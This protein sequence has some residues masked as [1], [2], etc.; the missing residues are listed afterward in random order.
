MG[1]IGYPR[2]WGRCVVVFCGITLASCVKLEI[3]PEKLISD[4]VRASQSVVETVKR[5]RQGATERDFQHT[6][7]LRAGADEQDAGIECLAFAT[8]LADAASAKPAE[9]IS[10][11][12]E[13]VKEDEKSML[14]CSIKAWVF[15]G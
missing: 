13:I 1:R 2:V 15:Q 12:T 10:R 5:K 6:L 8:K 11:S 14:L 4:T 9:V 7:P 3:K